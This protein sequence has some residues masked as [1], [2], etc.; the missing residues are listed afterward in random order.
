LE[1]DVLQ[2]IVSEMFVPHQVGDKQKE[3]VS[4]P[5]D[6]DFERALIANVRSLDQDV[7]RQV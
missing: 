1:E 3:Q 4:V 6:Q 2:N 7:I 5:V